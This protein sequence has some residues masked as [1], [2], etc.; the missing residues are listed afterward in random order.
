M[1]KSKDLE[2]QPATYT[3]RVALTRDLYLPLL[4]RPATYTYRFWP[5][6]PVDKC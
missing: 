1:L 2:S 6:A 3:Y 5:P 4:A